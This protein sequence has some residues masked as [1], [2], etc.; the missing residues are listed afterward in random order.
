MDAQ[1]SGFASYA[2]VRELTIAVADNSEGS[3]GFL[4]VGRRAGHG[5]W[6]R[7]DRS[8][9]ARRRPQAGDAPSP[10]PGRA[11]AIRTGA[12]YTRGDRRR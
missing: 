10:R 6:P 2:Q 4:I 3:L 7:S 11:R 9:A 5:P 8:A 12:V 1:T